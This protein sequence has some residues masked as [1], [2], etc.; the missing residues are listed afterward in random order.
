MAQAKTKTIKPEPEEKPDSA[1]RATD[2]LHMALDRA[3][4]IV[5]V[6]RDGA[7]NEATQFVVLITCAVF[8]GKTDLRVHAPGLALGG[9]H[10]AN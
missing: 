5:A 3:Q 2:D 8:G 6:I 9:A 4:G 10:L 7:E 1:L